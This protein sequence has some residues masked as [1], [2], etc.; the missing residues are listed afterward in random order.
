MRCGATDAISLKRKME[1]VGEI[2]EYDILLIAKTGCLHYGNIMYPEQN[3]VGAYDLQI[4]AGPH[5][6]TAR[7]LWERFDKRNVN[8]RVMSSKRVTRSNKSPTTEPVVVPTANNHYYLG[9]HFAS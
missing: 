8:N 1:F 2:F 4:S 9:P 3:F 6:S 5:A 7:K